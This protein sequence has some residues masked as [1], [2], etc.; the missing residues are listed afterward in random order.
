[1]SKELFIEVYTK[2]QFFEDNDNIIPSL[3]LLPYTF[4]IELNNNSNRGLND[5]SDLAWLCFQDEYTIT[6]INLYNQ[7][8]SNLNKLYVFDKIIKTY[9]QEV[10]YDLRSEFTEILLDHCLHKPNEYKNR[11]IFCATHISHEANL[12][13]NKYKQNDLPDDKN[14][15][16]KEF[17][18]RSQYWTASKDL[19]LL[20][21]QIGNDTNFSKQTDDYRNKS[22]H[23]VP[24]YLEYGDSQFLV[25]HKDGE[26]VG[27]VFGACQPLR[28]GDM[29]P[30]L[31]KQGQVMRKSFFQYW[32]LIEEQSLA[33]SNLMLERCSVGER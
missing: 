17:K 26:K 32:N 30:L 4:C 8:V 21:K 1:M 22:Q 14:I 18:K 24:P 9:P 2:Y 11:I 3:D 15:N 25:K 33:F 29:L 16:F 10:D 19:S 31:I 6:I 7:F 23:R 13:C 5:F 27:Y 20:L 12:M 28:T